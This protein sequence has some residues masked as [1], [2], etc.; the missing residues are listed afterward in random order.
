MRK[1]T[2]EEFITKAKIVH[3][4]NYDYSKT[5][6]QKS[7]IKTVIVCS[8][9]GEW[10]QRPN[11]HLMGCGCPQCKFDKIADLKRGCVNNFIERANEVHNNQY[12]YSN[13]VYKNAITKVSIIC[14]DHGVFKQTPDKHLG[15]TGCPKCSNGTSHGERLIQ[16]ILDS[17]G[18]WYE[19][20]K[21][22][23]GLCGATPN[24]RLRYDFYLPDHNLLI[25]YDGE[26]HFMS[27]NVKG[28]MTKSQAQNNHHRTIL[29][30][31]KK[32]LYAATHNI[33][34]LRVPYTDQS[35]IDKIISEVLIEQHPNIGE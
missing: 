32:D 17:H 14:S 1:L 18:V 21:R 25:E 26:H 9:H 28:R 33:R 7:S 19:R 10:Q 16:K 30:D 12:N 3:G 8:V 24:S 2:T 22:F 35:N 6:Y 5:V 15:G 20:E 11:D 23:D 31:Q 4:D 29:N 13:V 27:V 34:L